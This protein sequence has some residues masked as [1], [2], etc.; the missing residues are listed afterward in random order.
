MSTKLIS[1]KHVKGFVRQL[2][3]SLPS[4]GKTIT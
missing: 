2:V 4:K 3:R 1:H